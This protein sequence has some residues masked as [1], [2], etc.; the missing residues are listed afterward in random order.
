METPKKSSNRC[1]FIILSFRRVLSYHQ[2]V[3]KFCH[4]FRSIACQPEGVVGSQG[5]SECAF[6]EGWHPTLRFALPKVG[7]ATTPG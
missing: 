4:V 7:L 2:V 1:G 3:I 5:T 6:L